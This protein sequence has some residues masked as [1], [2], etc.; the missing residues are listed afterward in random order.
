MQ[1]YNGWYPPSRPFAILAGAASRALSLSSNPQ[2]AHTSMVEFLDEFLAAEYPFEVIRS[3]ARE[4]DDQHPGKQLDCSRA[5]L[6][7][8]EIFVCRENL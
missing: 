4:W 7:A 2:L 8:F 6:E 5:A 1:N 3:L